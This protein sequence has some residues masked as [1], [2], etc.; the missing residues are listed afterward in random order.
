MYLG[1]VDWR[2]NLFSVFLTDLRRQAGGSGLFWGP[3]SSASATE[4]QNRQNADA[5][6]GFRIWDAWM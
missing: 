6:E 5:L 4:Q 1:C 2:T 3:S